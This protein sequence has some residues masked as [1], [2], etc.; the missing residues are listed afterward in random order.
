MR[1]QLAISLTALTLAVVSAVPGAQ[2][3][4]RPGLTIDQL[5]DIKHP[6][7]PQWSRDSKWIAFTWDRA[8][9]SN[10]FVVPA[11]ASAKPRPLT[12][13]GV[14]QGYF[15]SADSKAVQFFQQGELMTLPLDGGS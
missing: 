9:V 11:D 12:T 5:I 6:S 2:R 13:N 10:L 4:T 3:Q 8:G 1:T 14:P 15:W 7:N